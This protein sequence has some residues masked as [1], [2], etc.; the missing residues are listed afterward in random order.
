MSPK[1]SPQFVENSLLMR[2]P[3]EILI[4]IVKE[5]SIWS[6]V[7]LRETSCFFR[8]LSAPSVL[9]NT[10]KNSYEDTMSL[11]FYAAMA[12]DQMLALKLLRNMKTIEIDFARRAGD[13]TGPTRVELKTMPPKEQLT[14]VLRDSSLLLSR[15]RRVGGT[16]WYTALGWAAE[17]HLVC[18]MKY[19]FRK[20][21]GCVDDVDH[22]GRTPLHQAIKAGREE[23]AECLLEEYGADP[24]CHE[25]SALILALSDPEISNQLVAKL[26]SKGALPDTKVQLRG[27]F[28]TPLHAS[29]AYRDVAV[30]QMILDHQVDLDPRQGDQVRS[31]TP[32]H[33]AALRKGGAEIV[34]TLL[35]SGADYTLENEQGKNVFACL[36]RS[37]NPAVID[38][39]EIMY[40]S[41]YELTP[42]KR[43]Y[44][45]LAVQHG[46][47]EVLK[48][49]IK[50]GGDLEIEDGHGHRP[51]YTAI[52]FQQTKAAMLLTE[53]GAKEDY[54]MHKHGT[55]LLHFAA[56]IP[57]LEF[58]KELLNKGSRLPFSVDRKGFTPI[59]I[60]AWAM[61]HPGRRQKGWKLRDGEREALLL[62]K[63][64]EK[65]RELAKEASDV[66][67][68]LGTIWDVGG[69]YVWDNEELDEEEEGDESED[70]WYD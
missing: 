16:V 35:R 10:V 34:R 39:L 43:T 2:L 15:P 25:T 68:K 19:I 50:D 42:G 44:I 65:Q 56:T 22:E 38:L 53:A 64:N 8:R 48:K 31:S 63:V 18:F 66:G 23:W 24:N 40:Q 54:L 17:K 3:T 5:C 1:S 32:L 21:P 69:E 67:A 45:H 12:K 30:V 70:V 20:N 28:W 37:G 13:T 6:L 49:C 36:E 14:H 61:E 46:A 33:L 7:N 27:K 47:L 41:G 58:Y 60:A 57:G 4:Q 26:L 62:A 51:L 52:K 59:A 55:S 9:Y 11:L 29:A